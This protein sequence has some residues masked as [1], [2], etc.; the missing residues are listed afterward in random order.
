M[1]SIMSGYLN[2]KKQGEFWHL[3]GWVVQAERGE[4]WVWK[5]RYFNFVVYA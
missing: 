5:G 4:F 1:V 2:P 3:P